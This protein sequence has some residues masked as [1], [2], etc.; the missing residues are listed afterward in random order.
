MDRNE[1]SPPQ[2]RE[3]DQ[4]VDDSVDVDLSDGSI[5]P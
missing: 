4:D 3:S 1:L 5:A 2:R